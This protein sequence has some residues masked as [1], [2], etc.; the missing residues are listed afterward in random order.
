M[1][2]MRRSF[3]I[4]MFWMLDECFAMKV[5]SLSYLNALII[6]ATSFMFRYRFLV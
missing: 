1:N 4:F 5:L 6:L 2:R 3:E